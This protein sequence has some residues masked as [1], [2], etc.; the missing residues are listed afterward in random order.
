MSW[1]ERREDSSPAGA[2]GK[3]IEPEGATFGGHNDRDTHP[4]R[5]C[6]LR[7]P[8]RA[9]ATSFRLV[10]ASAASADPASVP[11][12]PPCLPATTRRGLAGDRGVLVT[13]TLPVA[14]P[15]GARSTSPGQPV[16]RWWVQG[17]PV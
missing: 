2:N 17:Q 12:S 8:G 5:R 14:L 13:A 11:D 16:S 3:L 10:S 6:V 9:R 15:C 1:S 7:F 4:R